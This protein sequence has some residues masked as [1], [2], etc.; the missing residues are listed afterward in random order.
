MYHSL[1][2]DTYISVLK[3]IAK[4]QQRLSPADKQTACLAR[5]AKFS[6][7][8]SW[9]SLKDHLDHPYPG[10]L[11]WDDDLEKVTGGMKQAVPEVFEHYVRLVAWEILRHRFFQKSSIE[12]LAAAD[13]EPIDVY[14]EV[15]S[16]FEG[17]MPKEELTRLIPDLERDGVWGMEYE[18]IMIDEFSMSDW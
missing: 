17:T 9:P 10:Q 12:D 13:L 18:D 5:I 1:P 15:L 11:V 3:R 2:I 7:F 16:D 8:Q 14:V 4:K 6:G